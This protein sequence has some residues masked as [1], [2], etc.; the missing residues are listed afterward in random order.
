MLFIYSSENCEASEAN[1]PYRRVINQVIRC[2]KRLAAT[3]WVEPINQKIRIAII[4][5]IS[6]KAPLKR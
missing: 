5:L 6:K 3:L 4:I 2:V 1:P